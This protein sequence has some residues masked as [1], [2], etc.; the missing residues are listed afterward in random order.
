M[1]TDKILK[2]IN[3]S[4]PAI[5]YQNNKEQIKFRILVRCLLELTV[6]VAT[7]DF[8][9]DKDFLTD[10]QKAT[11]KNNIK[12]IRKLRDSKVENLLKEYSMYF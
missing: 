9:Y 12:T 1:D 8:I 7:L 6:E 3:K 2:I 4:N 5:N 10:D 11:I